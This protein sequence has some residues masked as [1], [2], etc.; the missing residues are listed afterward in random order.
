MKIALIIKRLNTKGGAQR[1]ILK[2]AHELKKRGHEVALYTFLLD[3]KNCY[4]DLFEGLQVVSLPAYRP[5]SYST[6]GIAGFFSYIRVLRY[7]NS[8]S[9]ELALLVDPHTELLHPHDHVA[10][11]VSIY[12]KERAKQIPSVWMMNDM[13]TRMWS[14]WREK[15]CNAGL[16]LSFIK[17]IWYWL[18]DFYE[19]HAFIQGQDGIVVVDWRDQKWV[20]EYFN[21]NA[22]VVR[23]GLDIEQFPYRERI[24]PQNKKIRLLATGIFLTHRRFEDGIEAA[25]ALKE[26]GYDAALSIIGNSEADKRYYQ[27]IKNKI[28]ELELE[29][30]VFLRGVVTEE[31]LL[32]SYY[33]HDIFIFPNHLQSWGLAVFEAMA[34]GMPVIVSKSAG[35]SEVLTDRENAFLIDPKSPKQIADAIAAIIDNPDTYSHLSK[36]GRDFV[37]KNISWSRYADQMEDIF[38]K[39]MSKGNK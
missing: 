5:P 33:D 18:I 16:R 10:Y 20:K 22:H 6:G 27:K 25:H 3:V 31:D 7:E 32:A 36:N 21:K 14:F 24:P 34:T 17:K 37:E 29:N 8:A 2:L 38:K 11:R 4:E 26:K 15:E 30:S 39:V 23:T 1:Q 13:P 35:A 19:I 28:K 9:R 12:F